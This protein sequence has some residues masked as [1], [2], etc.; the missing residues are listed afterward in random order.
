[1][2]YRLV[3]FIVL[4]KF[5][6]LSQQ[7]SAQDNSIRDFIDAENYQ[8]A[9]SVILLNGTIENLNESRLENLG[10]CYIMTREYDKAEEIYAKLVDTKKPTA[11]NLKYY[12]EVLLINQK[13]EM[14]KDNFIR[15]RELNLSDKQIQLKIA[16]CDSLNLWKNQKSRFLIEN[17]SGINT[18][19]DEM[20]AVSTSSA[21]VFLSNRYNG[22]NANDSLNK[23]ISS[24]FIIKDFKA[25]NVDMINPKATEI[26]VGHLNKFCVAKKQLCTSF[27][28]SKERNIYAFALK[29]V[30]RN[31]QDFSLGNSQI[32]FDG[33]MDE[34]INNLVAF[35]W[36]GMP[37]E[38]NISQPG[39]AKNGKR[40]YFSSDMPGGFGG[41]DLYYSDLVNEVWTTPKNLGENVNTPFDELS[42]V[43][44]GDTLL[45]YSSN[46]L[47]GYGNFDVYCSAINNDSFGKSVN[48]KAPINSTG[49]EL[50][51]QP[52]MGK[53][54]LL[55]SNR[56][57]MGKGGYD[58]Y[59]VNPQ[60]RD[61]HKDDNLVQPVA[62]RVF[63]IQNYQQPFILFKLN[64]A[65]VDK[66]YDQS[67]EA[68]AD[69]MKLFNDLKVTILGYTDILGSPVFNTKLSEA[70]AKAVADKLLKL[71]VPESQISYKGMGISKE[72]K[73][74]G[75]R[76]TVILKTLKSPDYTD[77]LSKMM[78]NKYDIIVLPNGN[79]FSYGVGDFDNMQDAENF[80]KKIDTR[81]FSQ[82]HVGAFY[83]GKC[84]TKYSTSINRRVDLKLSKFE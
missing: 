61:D 54:A 35:K 26:N 15:C 1:M 7:I 9:I 81:Y 37:S 45:Y 40:L 34:S 17:F 10:Y 79:S 51:F 20:C 19:A 80:L 67:L 71:G 84:L 64:E 39:F 41:M 78:S 60:I 59:V 56:F 42:P 68:L 5:L 21:L 23:D 46:G 72:E 50:Y 12:A 66:N 36:E 29:Q 13:Y 65:L 14:A 63:D 11:E 6:F 16:S 3:Y 25:L 8:K 82:S 77:K 32:M 49:D 27:C 55:S 74:Q 38:I 33:T 24:L 30:H 76:Y 2:K 62:K 28:Y 48:L 73:I 57:S 58:I 31:M 18:S 70:R 4:L 22:M 52:N 83:F 75:I 44:S 53:S 69:S 43:I 47:P